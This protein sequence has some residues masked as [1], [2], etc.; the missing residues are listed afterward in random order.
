MPPSAAPFRLDSV[1]QWREQLRDQCRLRWSE[2]CRA[3]E[4]IRR[5]AEQLCEEI[6]RERLERRGALETGSVSLDDV[7]A[8]HQYEQALRTELERLQDEGDAAARERLR[9]A[10]QLR[11]AQRE[12]AMLERLRDGQADEAARTSQRREQRELDDLTSGWLQRRPV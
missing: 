4:S 10:D 2:A 3:E 11:E 8:R 1:L 5:L 9:C 7:R 6:E 12:V